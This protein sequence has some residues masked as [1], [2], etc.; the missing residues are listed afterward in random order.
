MTAT[1]GP[2][3]VLS[4]R[5]PILPGHVKQDSLCRYFEYGLTEPCLPS[6]IGVPQ[7]YIKGRLNP[8]DTST[9]YKCMQAPEH[10]GKTPSTRQVGYFCH[11]GID[12]KHLGGILVTNEIGVP[13][14]FKYTEPVML[15]KLQKTLYGA[16]LERYLHETVTRDPLAREL[17]SD[18]KYVITGFEEK[19]YLATFAGR[20]M[21]ALQGVRSAT[22]EP[23]GSFAR[24]RDREALIMTDE[25]PGLRAAFSTSD[26]A[27]QQDI[28]T[29]LQGISRTMD[30]LE[31]LERVKAALKMLA[32]DE[33]RR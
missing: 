14:E 12:G 1:P 17:H 9:G 30:L 23:A 22:S 21:I 16:A 32:S 7:P 13:L 31:P 25:G 8:A 18:P 24:T 5:R 19:E 10:E 29:W 15:H 4:V 2:N 33:R 20:E 26:E 6:G 28:I 3:V 11:L 27:A